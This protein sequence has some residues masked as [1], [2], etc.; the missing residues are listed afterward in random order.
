[1]CLKIDKPT[2]GN[3]FQLL[4]DL[5]ELTDHEYNTV[6]KMYDSDNEGD[7]IIAELI[8]KSKYNESNI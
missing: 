1:M 2:S 6:T 4:K 3:L 5:A 7:K 8:T